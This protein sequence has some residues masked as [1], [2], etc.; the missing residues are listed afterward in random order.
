VNG[1]RRKVPNP[2]QNQSK[3]NSAK[4]RVQVRVVQGTKI[5]PSSSRDCA[6]G[7]HCEMQLWDECPNYLSKAC[8]T[9]AV[10]K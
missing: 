5:S 10:S 1:A 7:L 9:L 6:R 4:I 8:L 3:A 2:S